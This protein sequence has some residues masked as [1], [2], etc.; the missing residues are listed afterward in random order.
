MDAPADGVSLLRQE[1]DVQF[2]DGLGQGL[3]VRPPSPAVFVLPASELL[4]ELE[5]PGPAVSPLEGLPG[6]MEV[7]TSTS[8]FSGERVPL[9]A[10]RISAASGKPGKVLKRRT[11]IQWP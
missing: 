6:L 11:S 2:D 3:E 4:D 9:N 8:M 1:I 5:Q 10:L 7:F